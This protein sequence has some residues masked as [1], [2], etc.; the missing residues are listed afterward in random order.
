MNREYL[1]WIARSGVSMTKK[2]I[3]EAVTGSEKSCI[4][5]QISV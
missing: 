3:I 5:S 2:M 4:N 1:L